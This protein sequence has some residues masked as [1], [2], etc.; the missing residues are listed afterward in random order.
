MDLVGTNLRMAWSASRLLRSVR[1]R[2]LL[3]ERTEATR[4]AVSTV[5]VKMVAKME[6]A[7]RATSALLTDDSLDASARAACRAAISLRPLNSTVAFWNT[8]AAGMRAVSLRLAMKKFSKVATAAGLASRAA[9]LSTSS[10]GAR[11]TKRVVNVR[12]S[13]ALSMKALS[14]ASSGNPM[15]H[16]EYARPLLPPVLSSA[17]STWTSR[18]SSDWKAGLRVSDPAE[19]T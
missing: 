14:V 8:V 5:E 13:M 7:T 4:W 1:A 2:V 16:A 10:G 11:T 12:I 3:D 9:I 17:R 15:P 6:T 18:S 19:K